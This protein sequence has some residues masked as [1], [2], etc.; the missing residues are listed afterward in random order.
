MPRSRLSRDFA[1]HSRNYSYEAI[2]DGDE[3]DDSRPSR[4]FISSVIEHED[5]GKVGCGA[6]VCRLGNALGRR[7]CVINDLTEL[8]HLSDRFGAFSDPALFDGKDQL[9][10]MVR[11]LNQVRIEFRNAPP[12]SGNIVLCFE[13]EAN[14]LVGEQLK[15]RHDDAPVYSPHT[16]VSQELLVAFL[17]HLKDVSVS[18]VTASVSQKSFTVTKAIKEIRN[19]KAS[20]VDATTEISE[21]ETLVTKKVKNGARGELKDIKNSDVLPDWWKCTVLYRLTHMAVTE[22]AEKHDW[23]AV[24]H[25]LKKAVEL[26][27]GDSDTEVFYAVDMFPW[28]GSIVHIFGPHMQKLRT[29]DK[30]SLQKL[31]SKF[32]LVQGLLPS[33][34]MS[35][36]VLH[37]MKRQQ[38]D[39][40]NRALLGL[41]SCATAGLSATLN[42]LVRY[43]GGSTERK[44]E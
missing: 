5:G 33:F 17:Q 32:S 31:C 22:L 9:W 12:Y 39:A 11:F 25:V 41:F 14:D 43:A 4:P 36:V 1:S 40:S 26:I 2:S 10:S 37:S 20:G 23:Q 30:E 15:L 6:K 13:A 28:T 34:R 19:S 29:G 42:Y 16:C 8:Q 18:N 21:L 44:A 24:D 35:L 27:D 7:S 38:L 3:G